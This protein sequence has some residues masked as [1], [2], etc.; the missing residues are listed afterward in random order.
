M[1]EWMGWWV[2]GWVGGWVGWMVLFDLI[3]YVLVNNFSV[4][5]DGSCWVEPVLSSDKCA[6]LKVTTQRRR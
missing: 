5:S 4:M 3:R 2:G 6:L 1:D